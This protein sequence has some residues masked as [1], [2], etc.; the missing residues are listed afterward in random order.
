MNPVIVRA[1]T[2]FADW[3]D[4]MLVPLFSMI[5]GLVLGVPLWLCLQSFVGVWFL[6]SLVIS[7][8]QLGLP[9]SLRFGIRSCLSSGPL[10]AFEIIMCILM[11][12]DT[13]RHNQPTK[14]TVELNSDAQDALKALTAAL[15]SKQR[16]RLSAQLHTLQCLIDGAPESIQLTRPS[17]SRRMPFSERLSSR[18]SLREI[19]TGQCR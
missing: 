9:S 5:V 7:V 2:L 19:G 12:A 10:C 4:A 13:D 11:F 1:K 18:R 6:Q 14:E 16:Q 17:V 3:F 8:L 15:P